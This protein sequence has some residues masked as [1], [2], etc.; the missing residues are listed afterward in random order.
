MCQCRQFG[1]LV[2]VMNFHVPTSF[3]A[4]IPFVA[5]MKLTTCF[6][7]NCDYYLY[8]LVHRYP[9][10]SKTFGIKANSLGSVY[11]VCHKNFS[12]KWNFYCKLYF[13]TQCLTFL[14]SV[15]HFIKKNAKLKKYIIMRQIRNIFN[16]L[17]P[18]TPRM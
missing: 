12:F 2:K 9:F 10:S 17:W 5:E 15:K 3:N 14:S 11:E 6:T 8:L 4:W 16:R 1:M 7:K 18:K 13:P